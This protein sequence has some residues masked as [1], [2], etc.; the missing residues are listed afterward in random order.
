M[1]G[2]TGATQPANPSVE[3]DQLCCILVCDKLK[4]I[5]LRVMDMDRGWGNLMCE[6]KAKGSGL[7][8][9]ASPHYLSIFLPIGTDW[10]L[11]ISIGR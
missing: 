5:D 4:Q 1:V 7:S 3:H 8:S 6:N 11:F 9:R 10:I 2:P